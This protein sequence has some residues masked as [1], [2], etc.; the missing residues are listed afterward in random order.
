V[1]H[2]RPLAKG[3]AHEFFNLAPSCGTCNRAKAD[4]DVT[5]WLDETTGEDFT[6][7]GVIDHSPLPDRQPELCGGVV[8]VTS[9]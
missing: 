7:H 5:D 8:K 9:V 3:G 1:D 4:Q 6:P 2:V